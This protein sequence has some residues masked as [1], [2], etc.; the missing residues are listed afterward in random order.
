MSLQ[1]DG[2]LDPHT[3]PQWDQCTPPY[4]GHQ[5]T[6]D[7]CKSTFRTLEQRERHQQ[8]C[9]A[10]NLTNQQSQFSTTVS[11]RPAYAP[12]LERADVPPR[13]SYPPPMAYSQR[14]RM[15]ANTRHPLTGPAPP[16]L[17]SGKPA[18]PLILLVSCCCRQAESGAALGEGESDP[19]PGGE[20]HRRY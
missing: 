13:T 6:C 14:Q 10:N 5:W 2:P 17:P 8:E 1:H 11:S 4:S 7:L 16:Q 19:R 15:P 18:L 12:R 9:S 3:P 20:L